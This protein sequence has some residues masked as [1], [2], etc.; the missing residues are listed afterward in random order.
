MIEGK[1]LEILFQFVCV[2]NYISG[3]SV[4]FVTYIT[5]DDH[6]I[7]KEGGVVDITDLML[8]HI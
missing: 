4:S 8:S 2:S 6:C 1:I 7:T 5:K 3:S